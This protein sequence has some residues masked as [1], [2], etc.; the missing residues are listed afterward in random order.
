MEMKHTDYP[1]C[2]DVSVTLSGGFSQTPGN[3]TENK[4]SY[5]NV[6]PTVQD[7]SSHCRLEVGTKQDH[8]LGFTTLT[9]GHT[10]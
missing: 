4:T 2:L 8:S 6:F 10:V 9:N 5:V 7:G 1:L 3:D